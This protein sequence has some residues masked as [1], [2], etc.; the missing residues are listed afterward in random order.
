MTTLKEV[1]RLED[2]WRLVFAGDDDVETQVVNTRDTST[3][4]PGKYDGD[5]DAE[6]AEAQTVILSLPL[7]RRPYQL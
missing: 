4:K 3:I 6:L 7:L 1:I 2:K 5:L